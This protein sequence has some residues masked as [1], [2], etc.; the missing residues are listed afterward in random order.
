MMHANHFELGTDRTW[1][2][3]QLAKAAQSRGEDVAILRLAH[4]DNLIERTRLQAK[5]E[6]AGVD[7]SK[8]TLLATPGGDCALHTTLDY[9]T[10]NT[11]LL[12]ADIGGI[13]QPFA[14][15]RSERCALLQAIHELPRM[16]VVIT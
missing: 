4:F 7:W 8:V 1:W 6:S 9:A 16:Q 10:K 13:E 3:A 5:F 12:L 14:M 15:H 2:L 11:G